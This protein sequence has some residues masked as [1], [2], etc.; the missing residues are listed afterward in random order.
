[1]KDTASNAFTVTYQFQPG[2]NPSYASI[3]WNTQITQNTNIN[4]SITNLHYDIS[5]GQLSATF[6]YTHYLNA[7]PLSLSFSPPTSTPF[8][9]LTTQTLNSTLTTSNNLNLDLYSDTEYTYARII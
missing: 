2:L 4:A 6:A 1:M 3:N 8:N 9:L 7:L 5:S